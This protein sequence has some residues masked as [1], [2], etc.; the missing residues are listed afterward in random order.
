[1]PQSIDKGRGVRS[2]VS[3]LAAGAAVDGDAPLAFAVGDTATDIPLLSL[4][5]RPFAPAHGKQAL[6]G[7]FT[8]TRGAYQQGFAEAVGSLIGHSPGSCRQCRLASP[9]AERL[10]LLGVLGVRERGIRRLPPQVLKLMRR[11]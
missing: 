6:G 1:V 10:L 2:L 8:V 11:L 5:K 4:A 3:A 9:S 7:R